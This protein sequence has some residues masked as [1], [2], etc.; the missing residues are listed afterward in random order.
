MGRVITWHRY[1]VHRHVRLA[2]QATQGTL[3]LCGGDVLPLPAERVSCPVLEVHVAVLIHDENV[4]CREQGQRERWSDT[5]RVT[6]KEHEK[7]KK[8]RAK[9]ERDID[10]EREREREMEKE[11]TAVRRSES[12]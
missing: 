9:M 5:D 12:C 8:K 11:R 4:A 7:E 6:D 2:Q 10:R 3:Y 1:P